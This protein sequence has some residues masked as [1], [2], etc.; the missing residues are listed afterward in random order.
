[1]EFL[2]TN[3]YTQMGSPSNK[4]KVA[5]LVSNILGCVLGCVLVACGIWIFIF[6]RPYHDL[7]V[8]PSILAI[9]FVTLGA[10]IVLTQGS[11]VAPFIY[12]I[13]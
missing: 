11:A 5:I 8:N 12:T 2:R 3:G 7:G 10:L 9:V 4:T 1:M 6:M 13:F